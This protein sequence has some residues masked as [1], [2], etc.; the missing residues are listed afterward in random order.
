MGNE[1]TIENADNGSRFE[2]CAYNWLRDGYEILSE[3]EEK[4]DIE[5]IELFGIPE[6]CRKEDLSILKTREKIN[7]L[8]KAV[9]QI[10]RKIESE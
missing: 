2:N 6:T 8:I 10:N 3:E 5:K 7:E 4:I 1:L 9:K